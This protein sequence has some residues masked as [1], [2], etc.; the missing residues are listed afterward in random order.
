MTPLHWAALFGYDKVVSILLGAGAEVDSKDNV[1]ESW[2][3]PY[4]H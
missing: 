4:I 1:R 2:C 3:R